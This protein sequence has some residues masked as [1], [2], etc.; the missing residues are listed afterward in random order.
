MKP[1]IF[2]ANA[3]INTFGITQPSEAAAKRSAQFI[4]TLL[5]IVLVIFF[6]VVAIGIY[7]LVRHG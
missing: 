4:A 3:F 7:M 5:A 2:L 6:S 1:L